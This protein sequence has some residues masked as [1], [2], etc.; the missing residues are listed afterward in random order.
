MAKHFQVDTG[1][2][3]TTGLISYYKF[4]GDATDYFGS[5]NGS[6]TS[7]TYGSSS[8]TGENAI[9]N[10][11]SGVITSTYNFPSSLGA[12][13]ISFWIKLSSDSFSSNTGT[14]FVILGTAASPYI[15]TAI[16]YGN[17]SG[18]NEL[19]FVRERQQ[20][21]ND[22][23]THTESL[24]TSSWQHII[25]T[26]DGSS[27]ITIYENGILTATASSSGNGSSGGAQLTLQIGG[28]NSPN[29]ALPWST[30]E[31]LPASMA[32]LGIWTKQLNSTEIS[33]LYNGGAG[34]TMVNA[35]AYTR[36]QS[37]AIMLG[38]SRTTVLTYVQTLGRALSASIMNAASRFA[39]LTKG[40]IRA[41]SDSIMN[42]SSRFATLLGT[43][44]THIS[45][46]L[47]DS[48]MNAKSRF[49]TFIASFPGQWTFRP[50]H[51]TTWISRAKHIATWTF[52]NKD[53]LGP[54]QSNSTPN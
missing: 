4:A 35:T 41:L 12:Y 23:A 39:G 21:A 20:V 19:A 40:Q 26:Y 36:S 34:Q 2:T 50:K 15:N 46:A 32:E 33:N 16:G 9:F 25:V 48:I 27:T 37:D 24:G 54:N 51:P 30:A 6:A 11:S 1:G 45:R 13:S 52:R 8:P 31:Y 38:A 7:M 17:I 43:F 3:L 10:G 47:S 22:T 44:P 42:A 14:M 53:P 49:A 18:S 28:I 5:N 29:Y